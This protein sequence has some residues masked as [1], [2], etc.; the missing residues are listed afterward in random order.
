MLKSWNLDMRDEKRFGMTSSVNVFMTAGGGPEECR[1]AV[2]GFADIMRIEAKAAGLRVDMPERKRNGVDSIDMT[3]E[4]DT[5]QDVE[6][7]LAAW[8]LNT[9]GY[10]RLLWDCP[11]PL[12]PHHGRHKWF[13][14]AS[15]T[16]IA[17]TGPSALLQARWNE[18][19]SFECGHPARTHKGVFPKF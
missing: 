11:S 13:I 10:S 2:Q 6:R 1:L 19:A 14:A 17:H 5:A 8:G 3:I 7:F 18:R 4:G 16:P 12:R 15:L 9:T